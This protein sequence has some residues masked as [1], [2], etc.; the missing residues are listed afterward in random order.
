MFCL[1]FWNF[2]AKLSLSS[3]PHHQVKVLAVNI[4]FN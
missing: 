3:G 1:T 4:V 2:E